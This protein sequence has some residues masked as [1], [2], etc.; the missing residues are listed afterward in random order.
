MLT[1]CASAS[2]AAPA[3]DLRVSGPSRVPVT[4]Q[5]WDSYTEIVDGEWLER[6]PRRPAVAARLAVEARLLP[7][8]APLLPLTVPVPLVVLDEQPWRLRHR[9]VPGQPVTPDR[10]TAADGRRV[11][12]FLRALHDVPPPVWEGSGVGRDTEGLRLL[13]EL[14]QQVAP[15]LPADLRG[16][17]LALL[18]RCRA[19]SDLTVLR[20]GDLGPAHLL[21]T[22]GRVSGVIDWTDVA[23]GDP[24]LD[25]A[26]PVHGT[27]PRFADALV[28]TYGAAADELARGRDWHLLGPWWEVHHGLTGGGEEYLESGL[29][30]VVSRL[31]TE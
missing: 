7:R 4:E 23:L 14:A 19:A 21:T 22:G 10:L 28:A 9:L 26:W 2:T 18:D 15:L 31:R 13:D 11:G 1:C 12:E 6:T 24:A 20:H 27:P 29:A 5:G 30:G 16:T 25:L 17:G 3:S 8:L